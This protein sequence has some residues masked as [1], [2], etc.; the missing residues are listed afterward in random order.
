M[1][2]ALFGGGEHYLEGCFVISNQ[3]LIQRVEGRGVGLYCQEGV[4]CWM[5]CHSVQGGEV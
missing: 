2:W 5:K 4:G 3:C 1:R